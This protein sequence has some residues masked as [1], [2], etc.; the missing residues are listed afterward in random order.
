MRTIKINLGK[1]SYKIIIGNKIFSQIGKI[2]NSLGI[3]N[4]SVIITNP[5]LKKKLGFKLAGYLKRSGYTAK[6]E[7]V[8][9]T[10]KSKSAKQVFRLIDRIGKYDV[11]RRL[12]IIALGGGVVGDL[13]GF[14]A[15][16]Y[17]RGINYI[18]IPTTF[19]GQID[20]AIG[21]KTAVDLSLGKNLVGA[22]YQ[23]RL[24]LSDISVLSSLDKKQIRSGLAEAIKY[25]I[26]KDKQLFE[27][28]EKNHAKILSLNKT[29]LEYIVYRCSAIK[30]KV[31]QVDEMET[32]GLRTILNYGHTIGHAL[33][34]A[35][36]YRDYS[37][38]EAVALGM[39]AAA[40]IARDLDM[41]DEKSCRRIKNL[42][43]KVGL[44]SSVRK[45]SKSRLLN[46]TSHDKKFIRG[47]NRFVLPVRIG[48]VVVREGIPISVIKKSID[49]LIK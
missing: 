18:Q 41:L 6:I 11:K 49:S 37:H 24:V 36:G 16:I 46:A 34:T 20:S 32:K 21:G 42:I 35:G 13:S 28:I 17:K 45:I 10:E 40:R 1:R 7:T 22:F 27:F 30:A 8:P 33:E 15:A 23:P 39:I 4:D 2:L 38:G 44:P 12:F 19:L 31:V 25:G 26:I 9:D 29:A 47:K 14:V 43:S 5:F 3:G 48:K